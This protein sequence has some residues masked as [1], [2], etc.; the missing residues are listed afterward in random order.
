MKTQES[1]ENYLE[2]IFI[3]SQDGTLVRS[4]DIAEKLN[5]TKPSV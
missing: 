2:T 3:L 4:M 1:S 5:Y